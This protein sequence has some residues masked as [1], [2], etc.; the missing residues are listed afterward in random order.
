[1]NNGESPLQQRMRELGIEAAQQAAADRRAE[2]AAADQQ[3]QRDATGKR[4]LQMFINE[5]RR[6][7]IAPTPIYGATEAG[8]NFSG[9]MTYR[10]SVL[11]REGWVLQAPNR[12]SAPDYEDMCNG[13]IIMS[14]ATLVYYRY[15]HNDRWYSD[16]VTGVRGLRAKSLLVAAN[17]SAY[18]DKLVYLPLS[19]AENIDWIAEVARRHIQAAGRRD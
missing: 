9:D 2:Q 4:N 11:N 16:K 15:W 18:S 6:A 7:G 17:G 12:G 13:L 19:T 10:I 5:M 1:V 3:A 8:K 14:D